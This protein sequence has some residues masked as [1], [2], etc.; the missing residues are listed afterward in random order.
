MSLRIS[1]LNKKKT[2]HQDGSV[3][4]HTLFGWH[5]DRFH[6]SGC[7]SQQR[8]SRDSGEDHPPEEIEGKGTARRDGNWRG[9]HL[10]R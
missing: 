4:Q 2:G 10:F 3:I 6:E 1:G 8:P 5:F 9:A 7:P